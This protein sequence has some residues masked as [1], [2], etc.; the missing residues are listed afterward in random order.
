M[1][2]DFDE[3]FVF[4]SVCHSLVF[5]NS[6]SLQTKAFISWG[7]IMHLQLLHLQCRTQFQQSL[8]S[9]LL[10]WGNWGLAPCSSESV[11]LWI[12]FSSDLF[13]SASISQAWEGWY[14]KEIWTGKG[15]GNHC[16]YRRCHNHHYLQGPSSSAP[17]T[18]PTGKFLGGRHVFQENAELD[19]GLCIPG[20]TLPI[21]GWLDGP[22][23][24][25]LFI[26]TP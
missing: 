25:L 21:M 5:L 14:L 10:L 16:K 22:S 15:A 20:W 6:E 7:C 18:S 26:L 3:D 19:M 1:S 2:L 11:L 12:S 23:G 17:D 9:W 13:L 4:S 24:Q 8:L